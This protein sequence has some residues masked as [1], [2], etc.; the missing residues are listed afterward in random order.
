MKCFYMRYHLPIPVLHK[1]TGNRGGIC[2]EG[3]EDYHVQIRPCN[4]IEKEQPFCIHAQRTNRGE[5]LHAVC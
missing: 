1:F 3:L 4:S 2:G 5:C